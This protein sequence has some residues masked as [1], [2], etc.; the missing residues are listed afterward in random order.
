MPQVPVYG[1]RK[2][3][4]EA[5][6]GVR[7]KASLTAEA[8]G[9]G[10]EQAKA[11][12]LG[13]IG[14]LGQEVAGTGASLYTEI[15]RKAIERAD[16]IA[17]TDF[18]N[19]AAAFQVKRL[20]DPQTGALNTRGRDAMD[21]PEKVMADW[22]EVV[23]GLE[24]NLTTDRQRAIARKIAS[25]RGNAMLETLYDHASR[26]QT[27]MEGEAL[28]TKVQ[29]TNAMVAAN[30]SKPDIVAEEIDASAAA[31]RT[32]GANMGWDLDTIE[33]KIADM[34]SSAFSTAVSTLVDNQAV[35]AAKKYFEAIGERITDPQDK[36]RL[37]KMI[38]GADQTAQALADAD[39]ILAEG[40]TETEQLAK[41]AKVDPATRE[42]TEQRI[43]QENQ[44]IKQAKQEQQSAL[45]D[46]TF[47]AI[48]QGRTTVDNLP[49]S[50]K[51]AL[52][53]N[54]PALRSFERSKLESGGVQKS[55]L[56]AYYTM[57]DNAHRDPK[58]FLNTTLEPLQAVLTTADYRRLKDLQ[59][60][61]RVQKP[62]AQKKLDQFASQKD[63][64]DGRLRAWGIDPRIDTKDET[65]PGAQ[66]ITTIRGLVDNEVRATQSRLKR[67]VDNKEFADIVD[68]V[69]EQQHGR[70]GSILGG[71]IGYWS[72]TPTPFTDQSKRLTQVTIDDITEKERAEITETLRARHLPVSPVTIRDFYIKQQ[73]EEIALQ[74]LK[75]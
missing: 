18:E 41:A 63:T 43:R 15:R 50:T 12:R 40:G 65:G 29:N 46:S 36:A 25:R 33:S 44:R 3:D 2:V 49:E 8:A 19:A 66:E 28:Q 7:Q 54:L 37:Q 4:T 53:S 10:V 17:A 62:E 20:H 75:Q 23:S 72:A 6:P 30:A 34:E 31:I 22:Q 61:L 68:G 60:E 48:D 21:Q 51:V 64:F 32:H 38:T 57:L 42:H 55:D 11:D 27:R 26:E 56:Q 5:L 58:T 9:V 13:A 70:K 47:A 35:P 71:L 39:R 67:E 24:A 14:R 74:R 73:R 59:S 1:G 52:G 45:L 16:D 69:L